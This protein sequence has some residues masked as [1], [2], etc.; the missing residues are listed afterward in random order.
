MAKKQRHFHKAE[1]SLDIFQGRLLEIQAAVNNLIEKYG[2]DAFIEIELY[3]DSE[4]GVGG[5][6]TDYV[7]D[8][9]TLYSTSE[10]SEL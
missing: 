5:V 1:L 9:V 8:Y 2:S 10:R 3:I 4:R 6:P 7:A